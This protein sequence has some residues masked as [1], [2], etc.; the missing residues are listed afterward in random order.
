MFGFPF[1][2]HEQAKDCGPACLRMIAEYYGK[3]I[4]SHKLYLISR[5]SKDG[6]SLLGLAEASETI[7]FHAVGALFSFKELIKEVKLPAVLHVNQNHFVVI[8]PKSNSKIIRIADPVKGMY[9][10]SYNEFIQLWHS[11]YIILP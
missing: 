9:T 8:L 5:L 11:F 1:Y 6:T 2:S 7:G 10:L 3:Q 4:S